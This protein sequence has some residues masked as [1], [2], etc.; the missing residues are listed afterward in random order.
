MRPIIIV[1]CA[2]LSSCAITSGNMRGP[3]GA[4][5]HFIDG[6]SAS[7]A[8]AKAN[9]L[10]PSGYRILGEPRQTSVVDYEMT[11]ECKSPDDGIHMPVPENPATQHPIRYR[12][13]DL[14]GHPY[15]TNTPAPGCVVE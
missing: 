13:T 4:P 8:Y 14:E 7:V 9:Q 11:V 15:V 3:N 10:C 5:V 12:C 2:A 1:F 6:M